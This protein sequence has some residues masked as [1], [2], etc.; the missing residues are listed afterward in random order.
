MKDSFSFIYK[1][2]RTNWTGVTHQYTVLQETEKTWKILNRPK[3]QR[4][5]LKKITEKAFFFCGNNKLTEGAFV[6]QPSSNAGNSDGR[7]VWVMTDHCF[8]FYITG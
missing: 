7:I 5:V 1:E 6:T 8:M 2:L 3:L 4:G